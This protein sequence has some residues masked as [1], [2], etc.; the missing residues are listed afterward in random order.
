MKRDKFL[1]KRI[2]TITDS[3]GFA[4]NERY[5][6]SP[7]E[8]HMLIQYPGSR[9]NLSTKFYY[10]NEKMGANIFYIVAAAMSDIHMHTY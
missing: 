9:L 8:Y 10:L 3:Y 1:K 6:I 7:Q 2:F 4:L 5:K